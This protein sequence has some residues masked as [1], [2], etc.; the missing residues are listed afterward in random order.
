MKLTVILCMS[1]L[2]NPL[3][4]L[5]VRAQQP[6]QAKDNGLG[7]QDEAISGCLTK[8][9]LKEYELVDE[10]G[11]DNLPYSTVVDLNKYVGHTVTLV[12]RRAAAPSAETNA[13]PV[14]THFMVMNVQ[15]ASGECTK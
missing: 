13:G 4:P 15:S 8:N 14:K 1:L 6:P 12:G 11:R 10:K 2:L 7:H 9:A 3:A 5:A